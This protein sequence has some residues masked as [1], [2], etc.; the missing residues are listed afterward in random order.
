MSLAAVKKP[1][2]GKLRL[3]NPLNPISESPNEDPGQTQ[4]KAG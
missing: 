2:K 1:R 3:T 4:A